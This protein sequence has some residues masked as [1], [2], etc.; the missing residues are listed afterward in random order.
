MNVMAQLEFNG[1]CRQA[2][3]KYAE[4]LGGEIRVMNAHGD[5]EDIA[6]P[7]GSTRGA[8]DMIR[9]ADLQIGDDHLLGNDLPANEYRLPR[10]FNIALHVK[11][12]EKARRL[13]NGLADGGKIATPLAKVEWAEL[14]GLV[15]DRFGVPWLVLA[16]ND[17]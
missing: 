11:G 5:T 13:F 1:D 6:L 14:F 2:F 10:G 16:F 15:T 9:F 17:S 3:E 12:V 4:L 8:P 7:P